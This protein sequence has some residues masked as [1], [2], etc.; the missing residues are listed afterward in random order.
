MT[1][2]PARNDV[3]SMVRIARLY[4]ESGLN[5]PQIAERLGIS[6]AKVSRLLRQ[7]IDRDI[8][9]I[10]VRTPPGVHA[11][12]EEAIEREYGI[13]EA[14]V[15]DTSTDDRQML[16]DLG[17]AA[18]YHLESIIRTGDVVGISSWSESL[19]A[20]VD[21]MAP[22]NTVRDVRV[23]QILGGVGDPI[24]E[25]DATELARNLAATLRGEPVLL[26]VPGVV[27]TSEARAVLERDE[28]VRQALDL[29]PQV[30]IALV[31]VGT[32][33]P[34]PLLARS[35]N[36][37]SRDELE[38]V[39]ELGGVGDI[40]LR[41]FDRHGAPVPNPLDERVIGIDLEMVSRVPRCVAVA[42]GER[43]H[44]AIKAALTG[45]L[46]THLVTDR[47]TGEALVS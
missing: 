10:T 34:S 27:G 4:Y 44:V 40:C 33:D 42:G 19:R 38:L 30:S 28:H 2:V 3:R 21:A 20:T 43:K 45:G 24:A 16:R 26:P 47:A 37:F 6:Q 22:V 23:V 11:Q 35:G 36:V 31:G 13:P 1:D 25:R 14:I 15:V 18:A 32:L 39:G 29:F 5:Q 41:F 8:V 17:G 46:V 12:L 7:A 9:R